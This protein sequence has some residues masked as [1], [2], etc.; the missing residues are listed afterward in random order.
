[1]I[2]I[3]NKWRQLA[4]FLRWLYSINFDELTIFKF[5]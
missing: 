1:M 5:K 4:V 2:K 3:K